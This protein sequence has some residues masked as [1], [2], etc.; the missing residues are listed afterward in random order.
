M[1]SG[2]LR[3]PLPD[4]STHVKALMQQRGITPIALARKMHVHHQTAYRLLKRNDWLVSEIVLV[5]ELLG[6]NLFLFFTP[7][8]NRELLEKD[9]LLKA[10]SAEIE[11]LKKENVLLREIAGA[12][13]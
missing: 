11:Q 5:G 10:Q 3:S 7:Q 6:S 8:Q 1:K 4:L 2:R 9:A 13:K 12:G